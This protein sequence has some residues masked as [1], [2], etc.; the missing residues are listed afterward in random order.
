MVHVVFWVSRVC[1]P[2]AE[3]FDHLIVNNLE[4]LSRKKSSIVQLVT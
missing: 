2:A 1:N 3:R 4:H